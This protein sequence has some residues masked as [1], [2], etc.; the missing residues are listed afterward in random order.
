MSV[1][2][3]L[4]DLQLGR[5]RRQ[6]LESMCAVL[7][8]LG[9]ECKRYGPEFSSASD[10]ENLETQ[11]GLTDGAHV[12]YAAQVLPRL[13]QTSSKDFI[14]ATEGW[15]ELLFKGTLEGTRGRYRGKPVVELWIDYPDSFAKFRVFATQALRDFSAGVRKQ[16]SFS[17]V[18]IS[19]RPYLPVGGVGAPQAEIHE[20][21]P[22]EWAYG[23]EH[24]DYS[25]RGIPVVAPDWGAYSET[26][27]HGVTG[28]LYRT[29]SGRTKA[30]KEAK[31]LPSRQIT[32]WIE[33]RFSLELAARQISK[34]MRLLANA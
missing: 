14:I 30:M 18:W 9:F 25:R 12:S 8:K 13:E 27:A 29:S 31:L 28:L 24:L 16:S 1:C 22:D 15:H 7:E 10:A 19:A 4:E 6:R 3:I 26:V 23:T 5:F 17:D 33:P 2:H 34:F 21:E 11:A 20:A 32:A